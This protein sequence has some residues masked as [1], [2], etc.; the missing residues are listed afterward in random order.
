MYLHA[1]IV[2]CPWSLVQT[3][4]DSVPYLYP[5]LPPLVNSVSTTLIGFHLT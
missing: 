4:S 2:N 3:D 5:Y 1:G